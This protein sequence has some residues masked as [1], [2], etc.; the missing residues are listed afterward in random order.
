MYETQKELVD[1]AIPKINDLAE[2]MV[3]TIPLLR[4]SSL[5]ANDDNP[6]IV[7]SMPIFMLEDAIE[8]IKTIKK[9]GEE[10]KETRERELVLDI[11]TIAFSIIPF[12]GE[13]AAALGGVAFLART[14]TIIA[15]IGNETFNIV[16]IV[17]D[18]LSAPFAI[19]EMLIGALGIKPNAPRTVFK[20][21]AYVRPALDEGKL[22]LFSQEFQRNCG[23]SWLEAW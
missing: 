4:M 13:A 23:R 7:F 16:E 6:V 21:A 3:W 19:L 8:T 9:I 12:V 17:E 20:S 5:K 14:A 22:R 2:L 10:Q 11:L 1:E 15:E 18:P